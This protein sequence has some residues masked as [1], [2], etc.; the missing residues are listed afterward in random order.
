VEIE[1][2]GQVLVRTCS[3]ER[4]RPA[5]RIALSV[6]PD[7]AHRPGERPRHVRL[8]GEARLHQENAAIGL[9]DQALRS[10]GHDDHALI[11]FDPWTVARVDDTVLN[12]AGERSAKAC[13]PKKPDRYWSA[14]ARPR[15]CVKPNDFSR[16]SWLCQEL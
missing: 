15:A 10:S 11:R 5:G 3:T 9:G 12:G 8:L 7:R 6:A 1:R 13:G 2:T 14:P 4:R 16:G